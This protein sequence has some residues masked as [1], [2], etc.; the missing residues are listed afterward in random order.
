MNWKLSLMI[1]AGCALLSQAAYSQQRPGHPKRG[2]RPSREAMLLGYIHQANQNE[3]AMS[4]LALENSSSTPVKDFANRMIT[5]HTQADDQVLA[6][7]DSHKINVPTLAQMKSDRAERQAQ[8]MELGNRD[9]T[10][11]SETGEYAFDNTKVGGPGFGFD[12]QATMDK[13]RGLKGPDFDREFASAMVKDHQLVADRLNHA[14]TGDRAG[15]YGTR[16]TRDPDEI[17]LI[18]QV[19]SV[20]N[21]HLSMAH[22]LQDGLSS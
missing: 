22:K 2:N 14:L 8:R 15:V 18:K 12:F 7:A 4:K 11:G 13:L 20:V 6:F 17:K 5:D 1:A 19:L 21:Q 16:G 10:I 3:I 9:N